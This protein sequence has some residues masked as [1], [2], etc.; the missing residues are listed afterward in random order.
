MQVFGLK[1]ENLLHIVSAGLLTAQPLRCLYGALCENGT[2]F[3]T[4]DELQ[5]FVFGCEDDHM[6]A[7]NAA[8]AQG[9]KANCTWLARPSH[10]I[11]ASLAVILQVNRTAFGGG[12][13]QQQR[14]PGRRVDFVAMV[15]FDY[16]DVPVFAQLAGSLLNQCGQHGNAQR[17][18]S[19]LQ[20]RNI[21][22]GI[23][24]QEMVA[25]FQSGRAD[26]DGFSCRDT[27]I[28]IGFDRMWT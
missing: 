19:G 11:A 9:G 21:A 12:L 24:N 28:K 17:R 10:A 20:H 18:I 25:F 22:R 6:V 2:G 15:H 4:V 23:V 3:G 13:A 7:G 26:D 16:F 1:A 14:C 5:A 8:A 27:G